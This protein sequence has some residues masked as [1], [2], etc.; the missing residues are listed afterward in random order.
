M[1]NEPL[2]GDYKD[3]QIESTGRRH[4]TFVY[5]VKNKNGDVLAEIRWFARW[6]QYCFC[7]CGSIWNVDCLVDIQDFLLRLKRERQKEKKKFGIPVSLIMEE[8]KDA[9]D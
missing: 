3:F 8:R 5:S 6:R 1:S 7:P 2:V 4:K 9:T